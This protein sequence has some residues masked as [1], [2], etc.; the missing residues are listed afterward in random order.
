MHARLALEV[1]RSPP[2][3]YGKQCHACERLA[4]DSIKLSLVVLKEIPDTTTC[5]S[6]NRLADYSVDRVVAAGPVEA[7][8]SLATRNKC[9][10][11]FSPFRS[12][13]FD[14]GILLKTTF[15]I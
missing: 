8:T 4:Q 2:N 11:I 7:S 14:V 10:A 15:D 9:L 6:H 12:D 13:L 5:I 1:P 3:P